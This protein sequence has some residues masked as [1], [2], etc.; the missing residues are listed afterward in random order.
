MDLYTN[1]SWMKALKLYSVHEN[2]VVYIVFTILQNF[3]I[4][5]ALID[6]EIGQIWGKLYYV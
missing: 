2:R 4:L 5:Y 3:Y 1:S 6:L